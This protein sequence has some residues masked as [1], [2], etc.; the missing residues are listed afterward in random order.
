M[1]YIQNGSCVAVEDLADPGALEG[2]EWLGQIFA[3]PNHIGV[4]SLTTF[5]TETE[6]SSVSQESTMTLKMLLYRWKYKGEAPAFCGHDRIPYPTTP[7][8]IAIQIHEA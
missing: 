5:P 7:I 1:H 3:W 4:R 6:A 8:S 2:K